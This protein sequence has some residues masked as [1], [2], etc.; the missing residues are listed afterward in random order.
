MVINLTFPRCVYKG[1]CEMSS[2]ADN[3]DSRSH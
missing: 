3:L 1:V 2:E